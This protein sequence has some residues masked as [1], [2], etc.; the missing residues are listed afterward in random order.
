MWR[1][2]GLAS[3]RNS[4]CSGSLRCCAVAALAVALLLAPAATVL[5][6]RDALRPTRAQLA[7][8]YH[9][10]PYIKY[11]AALSYGD[12]TDDKVSADYIRALILSESAGDKWA[13]SVKGARGLT[14]IM[15]AT[16]RAAT[17]SLARADF[18]Y[19]YVDERNFSA[20]NADHLYDPA[21]NILIACYLNSE[22]RRQFGGRV[23]LMAAAWNAGPDA[24]VRHRN[25]A[26]PYRETREFIGRV[27][28][29]L[30]Y[31][32][33]QSVGQSF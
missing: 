7:R 16:G 10:E 29:Y 27:M 18:D 4:A 28:G 5:A 26:P 17:A 21:L 2:L 23:D 9:L 6:E 15:P 31:F 14:Q 25:S 32:Q 22:Y 3:P 1:W 19:R 11:F 20:F 13:H 30:R 8:L 33:S 12:G 24:V